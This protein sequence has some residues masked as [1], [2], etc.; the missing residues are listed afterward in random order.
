MTHKELDL[1]T[2]AYVEC[3]LWACTDDN[4]NPLEENYGIGDIDDDAIKHMQED[5]AAFQE[6]HADDII[7][8]LERAGHDFFLT[9]NGHGVGFWCKGRWPQEVGERLA[10]AASAYKTFELYEGDDGRIYHHN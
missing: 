1:F 6:A 10:K 8:D 7:N 9:R 4:G 5:C 2:R 3:A